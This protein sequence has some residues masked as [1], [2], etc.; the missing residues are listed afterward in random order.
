MSVRQR[1]RRLTPQRPRLPSSSRL[2]MFRCRHPGRQERNSHIASKHANRAGRAAASIGLKDIERAAVRHE[3]SIPAPAQQLPNQ[4]G[5]VAIIA[6]QHDS[7]D[8]TRE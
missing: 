5:A 6:L 1:W 7:P 2:E 3:G 4:L 8:N